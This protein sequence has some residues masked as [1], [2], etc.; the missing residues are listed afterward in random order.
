MESF[1]TNADNAI[2]IGIPFFATTLEQMEENM[3][4]NNF[5]VKEDKYYGS[6]V[7]A[8]PV[9]PGEVVFGTSSSGVKGFF[10]EATMNVSNETNEGVELFAVSTTFVPS[11]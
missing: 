11:S 1:K 7:N 5:K 3:F 6:L 10:G 4:A 9:A 8:S 2:G